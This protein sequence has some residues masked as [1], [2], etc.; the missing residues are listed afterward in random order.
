[1]G[2]FAYAYIVEG[3][4]DDS[5]ISMTRS[6]YRAHLP[7]RSLLVGPGQPSARHEGVCRRHALLQRTS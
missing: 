7:A 5:G 1:M 2:Y 3:A 4:E 6:I